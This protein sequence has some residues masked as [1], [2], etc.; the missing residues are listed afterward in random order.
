MSDEFNTPNRTFTDGH[1]SVWTALDKPDDD[2]SSA[3]GGSQHFYNSSYITTTE[4]G[5]L[6]IATAVGKTE[7]RRYD[8]VKKVY[9]DENRQ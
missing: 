7:W 3:G 8:S 6:K 4:D 5:M 1:D 2:S 9:K